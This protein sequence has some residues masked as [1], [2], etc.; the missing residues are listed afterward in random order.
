MEVCHMSNINW[1]SCGRARNKKETL[2]GIASLIHQTDPY[3]YPFWSPNIDDFVDMIMPHM[4]KDGFIFNYRN[5]HVARETGTDQPI[6]ILVALDDNVDLDF[7]YA[8][9]DD[10]SSKF[11]INNYLQKVINTRKTMP[12]NTSLIVNL[13]VDPEM[14][15]HGVGSQLLFDYIWRMHARG[16]NAFQLDCLQSNKLASHMYR[17]MGFVITDDTKYGFDGTDDPQIKIYSML[18]TF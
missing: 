18:Y 4:D 17:K 16:I 9:F 5:I 14:R 7:N 13:C 8:V 6:G 1:F 12:K 11:V 3:I 15:R 2:A 10:E